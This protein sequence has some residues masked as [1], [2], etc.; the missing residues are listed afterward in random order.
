MTTI[1][2]VDDQRA[3]RRLLYHALKG[4]YRIL[5]AGDGSAA[6]DALESESVDLV[7]L[8]MHLPPATDTAREGV[9]TQRT[10]AE[11][12]PALP[13]IVVTSDHER[14]LALEMIE[15]GVADF[16]LKPVDPVVLKIVVKRSLERS[17]LLR[18]VDELR[19][20]VR[21]RHSFGSLLGWSPAMQDCFARLEKLAQ[22][23]TS[24][25]LTG[26]SG[27]GKSAVAQALHH[28][29]P[30]A[31]GPFVVVD[32]AAIP[33]TLMESE[34]FGHAKGSFTGA[35]RDEPGSIRT[36]DGG[37]LFLDEIGNLS[38]AVQA[39][40][41]LFLD[42]R[43]LSPVGSRQEIEVDVRLVTATN[44]DLDAMVRDGTFRADLLY[45]LQ[46]ATV[47]LPPLRDRT[48]D[49]RP[50]AEHFVADI[51]RSLGRAVPEVSPDAMALLT[52]YAWPGNVRQLRHVLESSL[53]LLDGDR[54]DAADLSLPTA[55]AS[56][57][58]ATDPE[59][60]RDGEEVVTFKGQVT[61]YESALVAD[62]LAST[63]GNKAAAGRLL[64]LDENQIRYLCRK[65]GLG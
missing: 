39:K 53:V 63:G 14:D 34:L 19:R 52:S 59:M 33:E 46:V 25:L 36:A 43:V 57:A 13:V 32:P 27:T 65:H 4:E 18:E 38:L 21:E 16:L 42:R 56:G 55:P 40:L 11:R 61:R 41:L 12:H 29:G 60:T 3:A 62:A 26:E 51:C 5:E 44:A 22:V 28:S 49:I 45:R 2:V 1:L 47:R 58:N 37:T 48:G 64:G 24:L 8:D 20:E 10:I 23:P 50:L 15:N 31:D 17:Q 7:L 6:L 35:A 30:R 54:L 9:R